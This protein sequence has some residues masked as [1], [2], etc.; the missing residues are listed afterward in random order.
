MNYTSYIKGFEAWLKLE[1]SLSP[2][3]IEAYIDDVNKLFAFLETNNLMLQ[4]AQ[5]QITNLQE[6]LQG[7]GASGLSSRS[8]AR[9]ISGVKS[10]FKY[11]LLENII[12]D[13]PTTLLD[14]PKLGRKL[15]DTL[16]VEEIDKL[17]NAIDL[18]MPEGERNKALLETL[19]SSG[20]RVSEL[21]NLK[22]SNIF[23]EIGFLKITGKG[24]KERLVPI[25]K[26]ALKQINY[27]KEKYRNHLMIN[28]G[29]E[30]FLFLNRRGRKL[31]RE[32]I[33]TIIK[34][35]AVKINLNKKISPH[36]FRHSFATHLVEGGADLRAV[37]EMLGHESI[38]TTE[39][40]THLNRD[41]LRENILKFH[42]RA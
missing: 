20:L 41:Y 8:Q 39:I 7:I 17:I 4:P 42:P 19:Y 13:D 36:T 1:K 29:H 23:E 35:L 16:C 24:N 37:Q 40:Y 33:F 30:D 21:V 6:L 32:M 14:S 12:Q 27:Y 2:N 25:G 34:T 22:L 26:T 11:L 5:L 10:F 18:S 28:A 38:T 3:S 31:T 15:P 9:I